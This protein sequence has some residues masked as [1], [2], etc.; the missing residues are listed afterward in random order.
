[1]NTSDFDYDLPPELIAQEPLPVRSESRMLVLDRR[2]GA[3]QHRHITDLPQHLT[4]GDIMVVNDTRV[5]PAR[6][7]GHRPD[8][9]GQV[10]LLLVEELKQG[11]W[12][13]FYRA[14]GHPRVGTRISLANGSLEGCVVSLGT[15]GRVVI[16][17]TG[18]RPVLDVLEEEGSA[19]LPPYIKRPKGQNLSLKFDR[20]RYQT[21]Y[22]SVP[23]AVAAPTAGLHFTEQILAQLD[24]L[25]VRRTAVTLHVGPGT[26][27]PV[28]SDHVEDHVMEPE[29]FAVSDAAT[30]QINAARRAGRRVAAVGSTSVRTLETVADEHSEVTASSGRSSLFIRPPYRFRVVDAILTNFHLPKSTLIMMVCAFAGRNAVLQAYKEAIAQRYRFYSYGDCMLIL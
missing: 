7:F 19:P 27:K 16:R 13:S 3:I 11:K 24:Q 28:K 6:L 15:E 18:D 5:I 10:E 17:F 22:A 2:T 1:M 30:K 8:T 12:E 29:R 14:S 9:H 4:Q 26:F 20:D 25:G 21:I 23:G